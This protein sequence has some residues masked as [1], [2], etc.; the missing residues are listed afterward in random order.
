MRVDRTG[1]LRRLA[2]IAFFL[3]MA[4]LG[5]ELTTSGALMTR[6]VAYTTIT[7]LSIVVMVMVFKN[8]LAEEE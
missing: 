4:W 6:A 5:L 8:V 2:A 7:V 3:S 1:A